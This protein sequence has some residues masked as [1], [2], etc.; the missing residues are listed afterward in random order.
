V[1]A[2][3]STKCAAAQ[4]STQQLKH[5]RAEASLMLTEEGGIAEEGSEVAR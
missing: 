4:C 2:Q 3:R 1:D 5:R